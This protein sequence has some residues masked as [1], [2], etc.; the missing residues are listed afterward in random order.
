MHKTPTSIALFSGAL[1]FFFILFHAQDIRAELTAWTCHA[2]ERVLRDAPADTRKTVHLYSARNEYE[3][4]QILVRSDEIITII[5]IK[6]GSLYGPGDSIIPATGARL[7]RQHQLELKEPSF[8]NDQFNRGWYPD[9]LIPF[10]HPM[11]NAVLD[12]TYKAVPFTLPINQT[13]GFWVDIY[14]PSNVKAGEYHGIYEVLIRGKQAVQIPVSLTVWNFVLPDVPTMKTA[15]GSPAKRLRAYYQDRAR[16][17]VEAEPENWEDFD[18]QCA[19]ELSR[20]HVNATPPRDTVTPVQQP[21][22][23]WRIPEAKIDLLRKFVDT[24]HVNAIA[25]P[26][27]GIIIEDPDA[28][29]EKLTEWLR[30][31]DRAATELKQTN[32]IFYIYLKDEPDSKADYLYVQKWGQAVRR[33]GSVVKILVVEQTKTQHPSWGT[34]Y[35]SV[36]IWCPLFSNHDELTA[37]QRAV[38]GETVW[39]YTALCQKE[40]TPW[41]FIDMPLLNYRVPEWIAWRYNMHGILYW[42]GMTYWNEV[43]DPWNDPQTYKS[44]GGIGY[45]Y[46]GEGSLLYPGRSVGYDGIVSSLRLKAIRDGIEDY[47]Y[48]AILERKGRVQDARKVVLPLAESWF[49]WE[50]ELDAYDKARAK[51]AALILDKY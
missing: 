37:K 14:V 48:L 51:L 20:H 42:G 4:F 45:V 34:L 17:G 3:S 7:Y 13:H 47:E 22:G 8:C 41:W 12:G 30:A 21:D 6:A 9:A 24:Y 32:L 10:R 35:G 26:H 31:F 28:E 1:L 39:C 40:K 27:P 18:E 25:I 15:L 50:K 16:R 11:T 43:G 44:K 23:T 33:A 29:G 5:D 38:L 19:E 49:K 36:D 2:T 46:N